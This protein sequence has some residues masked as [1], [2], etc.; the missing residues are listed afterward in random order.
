MSSAAPPT[1]AYVEEGAGA[2]ITAL[3][4]FGSDAY[5]LGGRRFR[6]REVPMGRGAP[7]CPLRSRGPR[8]W[9]VMTAIPVAMLTWAVMPG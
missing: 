2:G 8:G 9:R 5:A 1:G 6:R 3:A 4:L 7:S